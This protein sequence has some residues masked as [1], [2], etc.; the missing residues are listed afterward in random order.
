MLV[1]YFGHHRLEVQELD[2]VRLGSVQLREGLVDVALVR[3]RNLELL[4]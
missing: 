1:H 2:V 4:R 3:D